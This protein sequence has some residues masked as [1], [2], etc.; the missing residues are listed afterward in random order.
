MNRTGLIVAFLI[1]AFAGIVFA[2]YPELDLYLSA[3]FFDPATKRF[4]LIT[5]PT[6]TFLREAAKW[7]VAA[8]LAPAVIALVVKLA[9]PRRRLLISGRALVFLMSTTLLA[10][11][12]VANVVKENWSRS[13]P[14]NT[15][16]FNGGE[17]FTPW[18]DP[19][20]VCTRN[21][22]LVSGEASGAFWTLAPAALT[23]P[24][25]RPFAY[26]AAILFGASVGLLRMSF[27]AHFFSDIVFTA[28]STFLVIWLVHGLIYRW[29][30][31]ALSEAAVE[32]AIEHIALP[33]AA[34]TIL[35][36]RGKPSAVSDP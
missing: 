14:I 13:R 24:A 19:R 31:S 6:L 26:G 8:L 16:P 28:I 34:A 36:R 32:R 33:R 3:L 5:S 1:S 20:G 35:L 29:R 18:W 30:R 23:P 15:A 7:I 17:R 11:G 21:C 12:L 2:L 25:W 22:S 10:P 27:G 4:S 9:L